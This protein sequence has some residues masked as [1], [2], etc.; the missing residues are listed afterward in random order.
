MEP[1]LDPG[2]ELTELTRLLRVH[3]EWQLET[4]ASG[5]DGADDALRA[6]RPSA[7]GEPLGLQVAPSQHFPAAN[8]T[9][10]PTTVSTRAP[11]AAATPSDQPRATT[12]Q[13][14][15]RV[16]APEPPLPAPPSHGS[17]PPPSAAWERDRGSAQVPAPAAPPPPRELPDAAERQA[18]L[19][20]LAQRISPCRECR[21]CEQRTQTVFARGSGQSGVCFLGEGP[22]F[23]EDRLG[24]PFVG[25]AGQLLDKM[26]GA[27]GIERDDVYV[28]NIVKCRPPN[29]R[30]P[31]PD[32]MQ[33]CRHYLT[34]QL[35]L[36]APRVIVALGATAV[37]GLLGSTGG[38]TRIRGRW[39]LYKGRIPVMPTFHPAY[40]LRNPRAKREVWDDLKAVMAH[41]KNPPGSTPQG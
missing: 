28:C 8:S 24:E 35:E 4:G 41:L 15:E 17:P 39:R 6:T 32:E 7:L 16:R 38:I 25:K 40:L 29:N 1:E 31:A 37:E 9:P 2:A 10:V 14:P 22:G 13:T 18:A 12:A 34:E 21:L 36:V 5:L 33:A 23:D 11:G 27:M 26:I 20:A 3:L 30:K 19:L